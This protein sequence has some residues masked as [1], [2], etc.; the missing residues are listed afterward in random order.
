MVQARNTVPAIDVGPAAAADADREFAAA[1]PDFGHRVEHARKVLGHIVHPRQEHLARV[2]ARIEQEIPG[3]TR[4]GILAIELTAQHFV[5]QRRQRTPFHRQAKHLDDP[6][7][8][9][10]PKIAQV[11]SGLGEPNQFTIAPFGSHVSRRDD[12]DENGGTSQLL[13]NLV[14]ED[15]R[16]RQPLVAPHLG[17]AAD[18]DVDEVLQLLVEDIHPSAARIAEGLVV[19]VTVADEDFVVVAAD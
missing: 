6:L 12:R 11:L 3:A 8:I 10:D 9:A 18:M 19:D 5:E 4:R 1:P 7:E 17:A 15:F 13:F 2:R 16:S 14:R